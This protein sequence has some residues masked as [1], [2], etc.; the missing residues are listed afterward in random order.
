MGGRLADEYAA[1]LRAM[2]CNEN[3]IVV[4]FALKVCALPHPSSSEHSKI[5]HRL[6]V[7]FVFTIAVASP[8]LLPTLSLFVE[9]DPIRIGSKKNLIQ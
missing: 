7:I 2:W 9:Y 8:P 1:F 6:F 5:R 4:P 3:S